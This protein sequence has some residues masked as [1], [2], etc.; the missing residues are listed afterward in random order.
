MPLHL[1]LKIEQI[2]LQLV[3]EQNYLLIE[4]EFQELDVLSGQTEVIQ[5]KF[6]K[7]ISPDEGIF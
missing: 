4:Q 2:I 7:F 5:G 1:L 3:F 6:I